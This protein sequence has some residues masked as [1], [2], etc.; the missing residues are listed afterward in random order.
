MPRIAT[1][2][3]TLLPTAQALEGVIQKADLNM[4]GSILN[5]YSQLI[6]FAADIDLAEKTFAIVQQYTTKNEAISFVLEINHRPKL[7]IC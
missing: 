2:R 6:A 3:Y 7:N 5:K 4:R 1:G